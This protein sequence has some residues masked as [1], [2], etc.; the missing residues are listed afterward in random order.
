MMWAGSRLHAIKRVTMQLQS[1][2]MLPQMRLVS[3]CNFSSVIIS[4][5]S[6][7]VV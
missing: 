6:N 7:V 2:L 3:A 4:V 5:G 1:I